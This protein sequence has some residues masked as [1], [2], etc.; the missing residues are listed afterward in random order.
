M[1]YE[2]VKVKR[3]DRTTYNRAV[4]P[5]EVPILEFT[6]GDGNVEAMNEFVDNDLPYPDVKE[7]FE[8]LVTV[9]GADPEN[10]IP[11]VASVFG[12]A[13]LGVGRLRQFIAD[14]ERDAK[15]AKPRQ[16]RAKLIEEYSADPIIR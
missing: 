11:Y 14:S 2:R 6:F 5:W 8:R 10:G 13:S 1:R 15:K 4:L 12:Q 16:T 3:D 9:Y 7:E